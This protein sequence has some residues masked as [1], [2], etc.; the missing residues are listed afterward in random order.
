ML[1]K[2]ITG[3]AYVCL[4]VVLGLAIRYFMAGSTTPAI[5]SKPLFSAQLL[6]PQGVKQNLSQYQGKIIVLNLWAT[7]CP[8][9]REEMPELNALYLEYKSKNVVVLGVALDDLASVITFLKSSPVNYPVYITENEAMDLG[10]ELG[11]DQGVLPYT[12]IINSDGSVIKTFFGRI[13]KPLLE[14]TIKTLLPR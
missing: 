14:G 2:I 3:A 5:N 6:D 7:W 11:N 8:P 4:I 1:K 9:C 12:V 10:A 13:N